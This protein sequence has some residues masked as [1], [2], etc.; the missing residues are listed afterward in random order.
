MN[1]MPEFYFS[2]VCMKAIGTSSYRGPF[3]GNVYAIELDEPVAIGFG[4]MPIMA[5]YIILA[6]LPHGSG[7]QSIS[8]GFGNDNGSFGYR[9]F[10]SGDAWK[11][12]FTENTEPKRE[13]DR[14]D[15]LLKGFDGLRQVQKRAIE[16]SEEIDEAAINNYE[17]DIRHLVALE[18]LVKGDSEPLSDYDPEPRLAAQQLFGDKVG[19]PMF[20]ESPSKTGE[21]VDGFLEDRRRIKFTSYL[22]SHSVPKTSVEDIQSLHDWLKSNKNLFLEVCQDLVDNLYAMVGHSTKSMISD[23]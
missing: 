15:R 10:E 9:F 19:Q 4:G 3:N 23:L 21:Q 6:T 2:K 12:G 22:F 5:S 1:I 14:I 18:A 13:F 16:R 8:V 11:Y 17:S 7:R 20:S